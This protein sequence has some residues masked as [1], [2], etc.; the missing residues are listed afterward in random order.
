VIDVSGIVGKRPAT[1]PR[2]PA[3][4]HDFEYDVVVIGGGSG[5]LACG[6]EFAELGAKAALFDFV[7]PSPAGTKWGLG[8]TCVNVGCIP[9]KLMH[10]A[11]LLGQQLDDAREY[12]WQTAA[13][14]ANTDHSWE[15]LT[16]AVH[17]YIKGTN[18]S[19]R[20]ALRD[21]RIDYFPA[22]ARL[23]D[24]HT[25]EFEDPKGGG[26]R[27]VTAAH[28]IVAVGGRP[29]V[30]DDIPGATDLAITR[31]DGV[32]PDTRC[33]TP[34]HLNP[35]PPCSHRHIKR[36]DDLF[37]LKHAPGKTLLVGGGYV[38]LECAGMLTHLHCDS[39]VMVR[40]PV[41]RGFD[42]QMAEKVSGRRNGRV[43]CRS[44]VTRLPPPPPPRPRADCGAHVHDG[45]A[46]LAQRGARAA[47]ACG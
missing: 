5:G 10:H 17:A 35:E 26:V 9:K 34:S 2:K 42:Q 4:R 33:A 28:I 43:G 36:S 32:L 47:G 6:R 44:A 45:H 46:V 21:E 12:G 11:A 37:W 39:T 23:A 8:G 7:T 40:G 19:Y 27:R 3:L 31:C 20:N 22:K 29:R 14:A 15:A 25:V 38:A 24:P 13:T 41:L 18:W 30:P 16:S 1:P